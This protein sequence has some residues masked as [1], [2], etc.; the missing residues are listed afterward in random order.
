MKN[1][2]PVYVF[3]Q[4]M[5]EA[6]IAHRCT[7]THRSGH[8]IDKSTTTPPLSLFITHSLSS[9]HTYISTQVKRIDVLISTESQTNT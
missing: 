3:V 5:C 7:L 1:F 4:L 6:F 9:S 8:A 2:V